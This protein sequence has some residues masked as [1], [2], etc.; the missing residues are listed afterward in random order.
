MFTAKPT[1]WT[2]RKL[3]CQS[4]ETTAVR[5]FTQHPPYTGLSLGV[6]MPYGF[7]FLA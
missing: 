2:N 7:N 4:L 6:T 5:C 1:I 3:C